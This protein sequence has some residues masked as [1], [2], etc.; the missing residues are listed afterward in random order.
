MHI[1]NHLYLLCMFIY[2][3]MYLFLSLIVEL[4]CFLYFVFSMFS[5]RINLFG[6]YVIMFVTVLMSVLKVSYQWTLCIRL[7]GN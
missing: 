4:V 2:L 3:F 6:I 1:I 7:F 5:C